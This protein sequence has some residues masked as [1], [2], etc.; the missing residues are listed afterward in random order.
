MP[1][2]NVTGSQP[3]LPLVP[4][5]TVAALP[6]PACAPVPGSPAVGAARVSGVT[7]TRLVTT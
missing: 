5:L 4:G 1:G 2:R 6:Y 7:V 3:Y